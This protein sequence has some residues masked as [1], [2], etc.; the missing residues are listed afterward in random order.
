MK[1]WRVL[2]EHRSAPPVGTE[3]VIQSRVLDSGLVE[4][5]VEG[6]DAME[7]MSMYCLGIGSVEPAESEEPSA[8]WA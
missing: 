8:R 2:T 6:P 3:T 7:A 4:W 1:R 5:I